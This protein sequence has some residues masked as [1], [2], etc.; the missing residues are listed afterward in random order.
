M[1]DYIRWLR[2]RVG[3]D[4]IQLNFAAACIRDGDQVLLQLRADHHRWGFPGGGIELG[5]SAEEAVI[6]EAREETGLVVRIENLLGVYTKYEHVYPNGDAAQPITVFFRCL[7]VSGRLGGDQ[8]DDS[9][10][11]GLRYFP[12]DRMPPLLNQQHE[13]ALTDLRAGRVGV[14]R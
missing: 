1:P 14:F 5:E 4:P 13:D 6:R 11:L 2:A 3:P 10:T 9:E 12:L 8:L 7:P